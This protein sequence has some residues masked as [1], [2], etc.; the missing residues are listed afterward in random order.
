MEFEKIN[1]ENNRLS[2]EA[3]KRIIEEIEPSVK[4]VNLA[5]NN[6]GASVLAFG[7]NI[8]DIKSK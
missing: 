1:M 7:E 3:A 5:H 8:T 6:L 2:G 4:K